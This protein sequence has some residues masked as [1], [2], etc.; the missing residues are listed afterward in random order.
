MTPSVITRLQDAADN[1]ETLTFTAP[2]SREIIAEIERLRRAYAI[3]QEALDTAH[4]RLEMMN[5]EPDTS[6]T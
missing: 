2:E 6:N 4:E 1:N 3:Q 5:K